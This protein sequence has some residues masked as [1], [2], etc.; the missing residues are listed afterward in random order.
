MRKAISDFWWLFVQE[1]GLWVYQDDVYNVIIK[2][3]ASAGAEGA[4]AV[5]MQGHIDMVCDRL[6]GVEHDFKTQ[7]IDL[8]VKDGCWRQQ[9]LH[10]SGRG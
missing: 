1:R 2:K 5:M 4:P 6:A 9:L 8:V 7:G 3:P 10:H